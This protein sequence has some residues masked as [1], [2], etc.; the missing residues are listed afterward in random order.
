MLIILKTI[1][2]ALGV[3]A[4]WMAAR[5]LLATNEIKRRDGR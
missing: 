1:A 3:I 4:A 2:V 5:L